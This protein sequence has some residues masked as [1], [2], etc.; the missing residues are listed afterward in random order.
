MVRAQSCL[1]GVKEFKIV[2]CCRKFSDRVTFNICSSVLQYGQSRLLDAS[3]LQAQTY[4]KKKYLV[5]N[6]ADTSDAKSTFSVTHS[7]QFLQ[8]L[9]LNS[10][11][12]KFI[13]YNFFLKNTNRYS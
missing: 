5:R 8:I 3:K 6:P 1:L 4:V 10:S 11:V 12:Q 2:Y 9:L 7:A 13:P